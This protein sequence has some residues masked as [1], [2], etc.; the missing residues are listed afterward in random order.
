[1]RD[2][3]TGRFLLLATALWA[4]VQIAS[5][6]TARAQDAGSQ[7]AGTQ[8]GSLS[9]PALADSKAGPEGVSLTALRAE[10]GDVPLWQRGMSLVGLCVMVLFGWLLSVRR[11]KF[12][13][14]IVLFGVGLQLFFGVVVLK[15]AAGLAFFSFLNDVVT[16]LLRFTSDGSRFL[17]G[18][19]LD[20]E[21]T[22][23]LN[24]LP[25]IIFFSSL[26]AVLYHLGVMQWLVRGV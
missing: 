11:D 22:V 15:T 5:V 21:F 23:A 7:D 17:F 6:S 16:Q 1:M 24:V 10:A 26:M 19:Y 20:N 8:P 14:R 4:S 2:T 9:T 18:N 13:W 3:A 12:P 25:T